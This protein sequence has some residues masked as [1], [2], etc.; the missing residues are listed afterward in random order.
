MRRNH[1]QERRTAREAESFGGL[2]PLEPRMLMSTSTVVMP[3][4]GVTLDV[5]PVVEAT[6][7]AGDSF[8]T[9][10]RSQP[11]GPFYPKIKMEVVI[12]GDTATASNDLAS[13]EDEGRLEG[14]EGSWIGHGSGF[15]VDSAGSNPTV[16]PDPDD[17]GGGDGTDCD[18]P[19]PYDTPSPCD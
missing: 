8:T 14:I 3:N 4:L 2:E 16:P 11:A 17:T 6:L 9:D 13:A 19:P 1:H 18:L 15:G 10:Q 7:D 12:P 5:R